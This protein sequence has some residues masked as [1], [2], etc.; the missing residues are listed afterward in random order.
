MAATMGAIIGTVIEA[1]M[2]AIKPQVRLEI[3][4][5]AASAPY[6]CSVRILVSQ[7]LPVGLAFEVTR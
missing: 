6:I 3:A 2:G 1:V 4:K 5:T 7:H